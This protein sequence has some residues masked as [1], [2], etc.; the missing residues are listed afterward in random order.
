MK[1]FKTYLR[2]QSV[3]AGVGV[4][5]KRG[6][7]GA[8]DA[9]RIVVGTPG[10]GAG[11]IPGPWL[12]DEQI[13][14]ER[15][16]ARERDRVNDLL[17]GG[18]TGA[19]TLS[20]HSL[21]TDT[22]PTPVELMNQFYSDRPSDDTSNLGYVEQIVKTRLANPSYAWTWPQNFQ[23][24]RLGQPFELPVE[25]DDKEPR[26]LTSRP[27]E[28]KFKLDNDPDSME[29]PQG[30]DTG[31]LLKEPG[32]RDYTLGSIQAERLGLAQ[33][34]EN[35]SG[36]S[37]KIDPRI[38][39]AITDYI[40]SQPRTVPADR[41]P[42]ISS[43]NKDNIVDIPA[44]GADYAVTTKMIGYTGER[45]GDFAAGGNMYRMGSR[46]YPWNQDFSIAYDKTQSLW[47]LPSSW[48]KSPDEGR[49]WRTVPPD[50][51]ERSLAGVFRQEGGQDGIISILKAKST[52]D[53][54]S[55]SISQG[56]VSEL[57]RKATQQ[58]SQLK[59]QY[60]QGGGPTIRPDSP[61]SDVNRF[62]DFAIQNLGSS[63]ELSRYLE[64]VVPGQTPEERKDKAYREA[65]EKAARVIAKGTSSQLLD[66]NTRMA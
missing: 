19:L 24:Y 38:P 9:D 16:L 31:V 5:A 8:L 37:T 10:S 6:S 66:P 60:K 39:K 22:A 18:F 56:S 30:M 20:G 48:A 40:L 52:A 35:I 12:R 61:E 2:E 14:R 53:I 1:S 23:D 25:A 21:R 7:P 36:K 44:Q 50:G 54:P 59:Q 49:P 57:A 58:I 33:A 43:Q 26:I 32:G 27:P 65:L 28:M 51:V 47:E 11:L 64:L 46:N 62:V 15:E 3:S 13:A 29:P 55:V 17:M 45:S 41:G 4:R 63:E 42:Y 34:A